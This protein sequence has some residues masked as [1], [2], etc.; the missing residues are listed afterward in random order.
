[1]RR[2]EDDRPDRSLEH[3]GGCCVAGRRRAVD[4]QHAVSHAQQ[5]GG[6]AAAVGAPPG[7]GERQRVRAE[8]ARPAGARDGVAEPPAVVPE[9]GAF[10]AQ[11]AEVP[12]V[13]GAARLL[14]QHRLCRRQPGRVLRRGVLR[15]QIAVVR[16]PRA[17]QRR[18]AS[19]HREERVGVEK[20]RLP[21]QTWGD[22]GRSPAPS[23][24]PAAG[25]RATP[26]SCSQTPGCGLRAPSWDGEPRPS[27]GYLGDVSATSRQSRR[28]EAR[29]GAGYK[30]HL[31]QHGEASAPLG[32]TAAAASLPAALPAAGDTQRPSGRRLGK[33]RDRSGTGPGSAQ[34]P[35]GERGL[36]T[37]RGQC[38]G[39]VVDR[40]GP[41]PAGDVA[42]TSS[43]VGAAPAGQ[44]AAASSCR[45]RNAA[46]RITDVLTEPSGGGGAAG[47]APS[48]PS[49]PPPPPAPPPS[50]AAFAPP[51]PRCSPSIRSSEPKSG[52]AASPLS[53][54]L[55]SIRPSAV[56]WS[57]CATGAYSGGA[58]SPEYLLAGERASASGGAAAW[59]WRALST[60]EGMRKRPVDKGRGE[61]GE[62]AAAEA[63]EAVEC[64]PCLPP[65]AG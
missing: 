34:L 23:R 44:P 3:R 12:V 63:S 48:K 51:P 46:P 8:E 16:L 17:R 41:P 61:D 25:S 47:H 20:P 1:M 32:R 18:L 35:P 36:R 9:G 13:G 65:S 27:L 29:L 31:R 37:R 4:T 42:F 59:T 26:A 60:A 50:A 57:T 49:N 56:A 43:R 38:R 11:R 58:S 14:S 5:L 21:A 40:A 19:R 7:R 15:R 10:G 62:K 55:G 22:I 6:A 54:A 64:L 24:T 2:L 45:N 52:S 33:V 30:E 39:H 28:G 53:A